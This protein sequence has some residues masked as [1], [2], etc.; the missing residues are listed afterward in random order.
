M[1]RDAPRLNREGDRTANSAQFRI[2]LCRLIRDKET[3]AYMT[4]RVA[5]GM[6]DEQVTAHCVGVQRG[7][8]GAYDPL[9][10]PALLRGE[11]TLKAA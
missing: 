6:D 10:A 4:R 7:V 9:S 3:Q 2:V 1:R 5:D 11:V 8:G